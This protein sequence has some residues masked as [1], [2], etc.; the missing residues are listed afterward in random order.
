MIYYDSLICSELSIPEK[1]VSII[2]EL[3]YCKLK[4]VR[5]MWEDIQIEAK[6]IN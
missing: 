1:L 4:E 6:N 2:K 5:Y 3:S